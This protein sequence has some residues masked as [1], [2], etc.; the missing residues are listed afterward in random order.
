MKALIGLLVVAALSL[1]GSAHSSAPE[2]GQRLSLSTPGSAP[3]GLGAKIAF[4]RVEDALPGSADSNEAEIWVM[5]G[6]GTG[7]RRL[8][9]NGTFDLGAVWSPDG[10]TV[11]FYGA[12]VDVDLPHVFLID[13]E[14]GEQTPLTEMR[15]RWPSWSASGKIAFDNGGPTSGDI[16]VIN[17]DGSGLER[18]TNSP[19]AR[20]IR[21]DWSPDGQKIA[22]TSRRDGNDEIYVMNADGSDPTRLTN[23]TFSDNAPAW[24]PNGKKI[25][26]QSNRDGNDEIYTMNADGTDQTRLTNY[27]GRDRDADWSPNGRTIAFE[28]DAEPI[29]NLTVQVFVMNADGTDPTQLTGLQPPS[30]PS[31]NGHPGWG[32]APLGVTPSLAATGSVHPRF[33][34]TA[35]QGGPFPSNRF[36]VADAS[37][38]TGLRVGLPKPDCVARPSD[39]ADLGVINELDGFNLQP[40]LSIPFDGPTSRA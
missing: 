23:N 31:E 5:N 40:R 21:P 1:V 17:P 20:N 8:T 29:A 27:A 12:D 7:L 15:S 34:L 4:T 11:A 22:F 33:D 36:T 3:G 28:R 38:N 9:H 18:V 39:C 24:S 13:A 2:H 10:K 19:A 6:D 35:P 37:E 14:G 16:F 26:F 30:D 25:V 32:R